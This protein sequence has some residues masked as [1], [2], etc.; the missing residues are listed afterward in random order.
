[1][2]VIPELSER[3]F[4]ISDAFK[5]LKTN[6]VMLVT[7]FEG[8]K[9]EDG[10]IIPSLGRFHWQEHRKTKTYI[11]EIKDALKPY[12]IDIKYKNKLLIIKKLGKT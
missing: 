2:C 6:G 4:V 10:K 11:S 5:Y 3:I 7:V 12:N 1:M 8:D 9:S